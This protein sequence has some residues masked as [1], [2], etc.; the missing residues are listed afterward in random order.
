MLTT[1]AYRSRTRAYRSGGSVY[2][3]TVCRRRR[4]YRND[5]VGSNCDLLL[6]LVTLVI[7]LQNRWLKNK[8]NCTENCYSILHKKLDNP[9]SSRAMDHSQT[10]CYNS[11]NCSQPLSL[12]LNPVASL[13]F[14]IC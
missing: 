14:C 9:L 4:F 2:R 5:S 10:V 3:H 11:I 6:L 1:Y 7:C 12:L 13:L 8:R